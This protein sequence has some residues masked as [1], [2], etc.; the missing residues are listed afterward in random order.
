[1]RNSFHT[2][3]RGKLVPVAQLPWWKE[4]TVT[5]EGVG[6]VTHP[7]DWYSFPSCV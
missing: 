1:M 7:E 2:A 3:Y 5:L 6:M 4:M